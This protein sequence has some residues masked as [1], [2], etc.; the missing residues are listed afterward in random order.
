MIYE[1]PEHDVV[2]VT[3]TDYRVLS[4]EAIRSFGRYLPEGV[5][6]VGKVTQNFT[7]VANGPF[8]IYPVF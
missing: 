2:K 7:F 4:D 8:T 5:V 1:Y 3:R 6:N